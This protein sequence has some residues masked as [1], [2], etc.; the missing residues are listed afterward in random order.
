MSDDTSANAG[1]AVDAEK[2]I[3]LLPDGALVPVLVEWFRNEQGIVFKQ[4][5]FERT[6]MVQAFLDRPVYWT[7]APLY[8]DGYR[9]CFQYGGETIFVRTAKSLFN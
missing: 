2:A 5:N 8:W 3:K 4:A 9:I 6:R 1:K 7:Q